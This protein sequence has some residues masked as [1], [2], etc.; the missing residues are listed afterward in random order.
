MIFAGSVSPPIVLYIAGF[1]RSGSTILSNLL[2]EVEGVFSAGEVALFWRNVFDNSC[3]CGR[4]ARECSVWQDVV[5]SCGVTKDEAR[6]LG[7][8]VSSLWRLRNLPRLAARG[9]SGLRHQDQ[10]T[11]LERS[12]CLYATLARTQGARMIVD[13]SNMPLYAYMLQ[14]STSL[15]LR[16]VHLVRDVR[17]VAHSWRRKKLLPGPGEGYMERLSLRTTVLSWLTWNAVPEALWRRPGGSGRYI[18]VRYEDFVE[19]PRATTQ[20]ILA[21]AGLEH[22]D[23]P[24]VDE[25]TVRLG[26][27]HTIAGNPNRVQR[28]NIRISSDNAWITEMPARDRR[29]ISAL[30]APA[31]IH[32]GYP[33]RP[34]RSVGQ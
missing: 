33:L 13:S 11:L 34:G 1:G 27:N 22:S 12:E 23:L 26:E 31:L 16:V 6:R 21:M 2:G 15:D 32:Y 19:R 14:R 7:E 30:T 28:G 18:L 8:L 10:P 29:M 20:R 24:F 9:A 4:P 3:G 17:G 25:R 5:G